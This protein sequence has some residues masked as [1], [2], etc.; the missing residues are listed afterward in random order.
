[1]YEAIWLVYKKIAHWADEFST[2]A[3]GEMLSIICKWRSL[4]KK[5]S[6]SEFK[7]MPLTPPRKLCGIT[8]KNSIQ[9]FQT[10][11]SVFLYTQ[12]NPGIHLTNIFKIN[13]KKYDDVKNC[14]TH[15]LF[16]FESWPWQIDC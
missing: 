14:N 13:K 10:C 2:D 8:N 3:L 7:K 15:V 16:T 5:K 11:T 6:N 12:T 4:T 1:M 9:T